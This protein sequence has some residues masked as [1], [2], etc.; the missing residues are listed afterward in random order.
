MKLDDFAIMLNGRIIDNISKEDAISMSA[1]DQELSPR[2]DHALL[3]LHGFASS[4]QVF[5]ALLP[6]IQGYDKI[7]CP[8]LPGHAESLKVLGQARAQQ[9]RDTAKTHCQR[10]LNNYEKVSVLGFSLG[11]VLALELSQYLPIHHLYLLAPALKLYYPTRPRLMAARILYALGI[12]TIPNFGAGNYYQPTAKEISMPRLPLR[13]VI[14]ILS[15][16]KTAHYHQP[17]CKTDLFL[18]RHDKVV[19]SEA[20]A[21]HYALAEHLT[22]HWLDHSGHALPIDGDVPAIV[23]YVNLTQ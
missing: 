8:V 12:R 18:G 4:P 5:R 6:Q 7:V 3:M 11:G 9:W 17:S 14:E 16:V 10:L 19:D 2:T 21:R 1:I 23:K 22:I 13:A 15:L 20:L